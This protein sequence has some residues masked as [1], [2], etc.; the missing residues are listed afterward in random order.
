MSADIFETCVATLSRK[1]RNERCKLTKS[2]FTRPNFP[3]CIGVGSPYTT[4]CYKPWM[5]LFCTQGT[6]VPSSGSFLT[7]SPWGQ[8]RI[9]KYGLMNTSDNTD[10]AF[11]PLFTW[12]VRTENTW[13]Q[14]RQTFSF[15]PILH[16]LSRL[17][18]CIFCPYRSGRQRYKCTMMVQSHVEEN[19]VLEEQCN[20]IQPMKL[21]HGPKANISLVECCSPIS[22]L[23]YSP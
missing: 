8:V 1:R 10:I 6:H 3:V 2:E 12:P 18:L 5:P 15:C 23:T 17:L 21:S 9:V 19:K 7:K 22:P 11:I 14:K 13:E 20:R 16:Y 4:S